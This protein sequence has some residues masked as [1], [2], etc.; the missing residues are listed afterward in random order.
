MHPVT[1]TARKAAV[2]INLFSI[3]LPDIR[4]IIISI[5]FVNLA[6]GEVD[7]VSTDIQDAFLGN[8]SN[9]FNDRRQ[10]KVLPKMFFPIHMFT[11]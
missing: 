10:V 8:K 6:T 2:I 5:A 11:D 1:R 9:H 7:T 4:A 3:A